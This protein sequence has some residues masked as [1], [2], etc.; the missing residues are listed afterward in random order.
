MTERWIIELLGGLRLRQGDQEI[1]RFRTQ[2][3][4]LLLAYLAMHRLRTHPRDQLIELLWPD[5]DREAGRTNL[6]VAL[7]ALRRQMEPPGVPAGSILVADRLQ[8][9]LHPAA[10]ATDVE[11]FDRAVRAAEA[12]KEPQ[13]RIALW[14]AAIDL[15]RGDLLPT[16]YED[17]I[18]PERDR[19]RNTYLVALRSIVREC[20]EARQFDRAIAYAHRILRADPLREEPYRNLMR[21]YRAV[22]RPEEAL[23]Q[24]QQLTRLLKKE[25]QA[26]PSA[27]TRELAKEISQTSARLPPRESHPAVNLPRPEPP[28]PDP[29]RP[30]PHPPAHL[31][32][33]FTRFYGREEEMT[34]L[35]ALLGGSC[36]EA[37]SHRARICTLTGPGG[38]GKTRLSIEV[39]RQVTGAF[40]GGVWFVPLD[41]LRDPL[42]LGEALRDALRLPRQIQP[43]ALDQVIAYLNGRAQ[44][45]LLILDN[46]EQITAGGAP[47]VWTLVNRVPLLQC[48]VT[49]RSLLSL[50]GEIEIPLLPLPLPDRESLTPSSSASPPSPA[51]L[52]NFPSIVL[53]VDRAQAARPDFQITPRN[54]GTIAALCQTLE[55][56]PLA[57][58]LT[59]ARA[60]AL[61]P[62]QM[63]ERLSERFELL[64]S[65]RADRG[66]RHH[67][68]WGA[69]EWSYRL[70]S[71]DL[72]RFF[73][74]LSVFRGS[75]SLEAA[76]A[77]CEEPAAVEYLTQLRGHSLIFA[78]ESSS[79]IRFRML[80]SIREYAREQLT[81]E[82]RAETERRRA[83][84]FQRWVTGAQLTGSE[85]LIWY[86]RF[87]E[88]LD[89]LRAVL[90]WSLQ[91]NNDVEIGHQIAGTLVVF[92]RVRGHLPEGRQWYERLLKR[93]EDIPT[94][95]LARTLYCASALASLT[96]DFQTARPYLERCREMAQ[97]LGDENLLSTAFNEMGAIA[98]RLGDYEQARSH[99]ERFLEFG[100]K[101][102]LMGRIA[103][104]LTNLAS[105]EQMRGNYPESHALHTQ[106][107][108][109]WR[110]AGDRLGE[111][112]THYNLALL[113]CTEEEW[114]KARA[115]FQTS[116]DIRRELGDY[117]GVTIAL[118]GIGR[119][120]YHL[121]EYAASVAHIR[122]SL[123]MAR[124][125][126]ARMSLT[127]ILQLM[128]EL[129]SAMGEWEISA[130]M[131]G[132][133][134]K[135]REE[136]NFPMPPPDRA[137]YEIVQ[138][139]LR[140]A[141]GEEACEA[142]RAQ[143]RALSMEQALAALEET[144][145]G[146]SL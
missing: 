68:L 37:E 91:E 29:P 99:F 126:N 100:R 74:R 125:Q 17:W 112:R 46:F 23:R 116:L 51:Q 78:E 110:E 141:L 137:R 27:A 34:R 64:V 111:A 82:E 93:A 6:S 108:Q 138:A 31:P 42:L 14:I 21:L 144:L 79:A 2:K 44:P 67:S 52:M 3:T 57:I 86:E 5:S 12:A 95:G 146:K 127:D 50:P 56:L 58:E 122:E 107:L 4:A 53:F 84:F 47:I 73:A 39:G 54:A 76:A 133:L 88:D 140:A 115:S 22:G 63:L 96:G 11:E 89:N 70:L 123:E 72:Q 16:F 143:G 49:S 135:I 106:S 83:L 104:A 94:R 36:A 136:M 48:L 121:Q 66:E 20:A 43:A 117:H 8:V 65:R 90:D 38:T 60:R 75:W 40:A 33:Q 124:G 28:R 105:V 9:H 120:S 32:M 142:L 102:G 24:Y 13:S 129:V 59:A 71:P 98:F 45:C 41:K 139:N 118:I 132:A 87:E 109:T 69:I 114:E 97:A 92:W 7:N 18:L 26:A 134:E 19:L 103:S 10:F 30:E 25:L 145:A 81:P 55:G 119:A 80:A 62:A 1:T 113:A 15:Y 101:H 35:A 130:R 85:Q 61:T 128:T 131:S 77:V